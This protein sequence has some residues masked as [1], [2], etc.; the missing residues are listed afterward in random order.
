M[1]RWPQNEE[2]WVTLLQ[3]LEG[4]SYVYKVVEVGCSYFATWHRAAL[5]AGK[6][7]EENAS[8]QADPDS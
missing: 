3:N 6:K 8:H 5:L 2:C 4:M 1:I 7:E